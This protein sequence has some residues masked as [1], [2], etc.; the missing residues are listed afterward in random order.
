MPRRRPDWHPPFCPN[1]TLRFPPGSGHLA[2][3]EEGLLLP[4]ARSPPRPAVP[5]STL[6]PELQYPDLLSHLL[7]QAPR[8]PATCLLG[9]PR[10]LRPAPDRPRSREARIST[11]QR[12]LER[13]DGTA[14]SSTRRS[15]RKAAPSEALVLD[16]FRTFEAGQY[17][18]FDLNLLVGDSH[19]V[20][21]FNDAELRRSGTHT[22]PASERSEPGS[23]RAYGRPDPAGHAASRGGAGGAGRAGGRRG[24]DPLGR[25]PG[26]PA[27][28]PEA[29]RPP[30]PSPDHVFQGVADAHATR[31]SR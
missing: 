13:W 24:G 26:L 15:G 30:D 8:P 16:G 19:Y 18:P 1:P 5:L 22:E 10:L 31:S 6:R 29:R 12:H 2:L 14:C 3:Q 4:D 27:G 9:K 11:V 28:L 20:Y 25:A 23:R 7:A 17:W 21:G